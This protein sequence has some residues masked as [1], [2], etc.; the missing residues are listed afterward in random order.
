MKVWLGKYNNWIYNI[1]YF[2]RSIPPVEWILEKIP[3]IQY[4]KIDEHDTWDACSDLALIIHPILLSLKD[5]P[6]SFFVPDDCDVPEEMRG[7]G[8]NGEAWKR[9]YE[10]VMDEMIYSFSCI[11]DPDYDSKYFKT[12][13]EIDFERIEDKDGSKI[14]RVKDYDWDKEAY[15]ENE[16]RIK[17][18]LLLFGRYFRHLWT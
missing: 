8:E 14:V 18:G 17:N 10:W 5:N 12:F 4:V 9:K 6:Y 3:R 1:P 16:T 2:I 13:P 15:L 11:V 7:F